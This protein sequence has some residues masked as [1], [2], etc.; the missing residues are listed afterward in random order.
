MKSALNNIDLYF[1]TD[2]KLTKKTILDD[3]KSAIKAGV[4][5]IQYREKEKPTRAMYEEAKE[6]KKLCNKNNVL[7]IIN[8]R[9]D[10]ALAVD[11]DGVHLGNDDIPYNK[12]RELLPDKII[13]LTVHNARE[14]IEAENLG[15][16]YIGVSPIF[17]TKTKLD[18]GP[19]AG[20]KLIE[21]VKK[22]VKI[23]FV[24]I[25]GINLEN[26]DKVIKAGAKSAA[27]ISAI[28]TKDDV[29]AEC[30]KFIDKLRKS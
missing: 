14:A 10:I 25:G 23:P 28:V 29:E 22:A 6:I 7:L 11:A 16:D 5:I 20:L 8:D 3:V 19:A 24:A 18:A 30:R 26:I 1:I 4:K 27:V 2:N 21:Q 15:A 12:A 9:I 17:E 13:G